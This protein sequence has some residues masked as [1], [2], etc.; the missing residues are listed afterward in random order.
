MLSKSLLYCHK[1][2]S[3]SICFYVERESA[4]VAEVRIAKRSGRC[5]AGDFVRIQVI[6]ELYSG[7]SLASRLHNLLRRRGRTAHSRSGDF[8]L[9][10]CTEHLVQ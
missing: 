9:A 10:A 7:R 3:T 5:V 2:L 4:T 6:E 8:F 1:G